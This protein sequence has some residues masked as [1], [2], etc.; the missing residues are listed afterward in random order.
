MP[1][2]I[3]F[4]LQW[5]KHI[6]HIKYRKERKKGRKKEKESVREDSEI[7]NDDAVKHCM[8]NVHILLYDK[9]LSAVHSSW[10]LK[11]SSNPSDNC[12][13]SIL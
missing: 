2:S 8:N 13:L 3:I 11:R 7:E 5:F 4:T 12:V 6:S 10:Y 1:E 9:Q